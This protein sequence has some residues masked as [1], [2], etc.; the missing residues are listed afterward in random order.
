M[1]RFIGLGVTAVAGIALTAL[2]SVVG[3]AP[4][5]VQAAGLGGTISFGTVSSNTVQV[6]TTATTDTYN[7]FN[8]HLNTNVSPGVTLN[9]ITGSETGGTL[10]VLGAVFCPLTAAP[11]PG[12]AAFGCVS[13]EGQEITTAGLLATFTFDAAGDGCIQTTLLTGF[14]DGDLNPDA[15][16]NTY[17]GNALDSSQQSVVVSSAT[18]NILI[19]TGAIGDCGT[20][21][22]TATPT[23]TDTPPPLATSTPSPTNTPCPGTCPTPSPT[24]TPGLQIEGT[25]TPT[26]TPATST[27]AA[28]TTEAPPA[29]GG[30]T[31]PDS[32]TGAG[33]G[34][35][36]SGIRLPDTG[37]GPAATDAWSLII[38]SLAAAALGMSLLG[39]ARRKSQ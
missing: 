37:S 34:G 33:A 15:S 11:T 24:L 38:A 5:G 35:P 30:S 12:A 20:A 22:A 13:L 17:T 10:E 1:K 19:G 32:G 4:S 26:G 31:P 36:R 39:F 9:S 2:F 6:N 27:P 21:A 29:P 14:L 23:A 18:A 8:V 7:A 3:G 16:R 25:L 28:S